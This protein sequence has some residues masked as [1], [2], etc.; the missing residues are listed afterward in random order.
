VL[1]DEGLP[2]ALS[3]L[4]RRSTVPVELLAVPAARLPAPL[5][6]AVY[7]VACEALTGVASRANRRPA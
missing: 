5:E 4:A 6:A 2:A 7:F 1:T 3:A